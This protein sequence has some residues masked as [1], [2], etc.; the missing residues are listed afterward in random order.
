MT[1]TDFLKSTTV[2]DIKSSVHSNPSIRSIFVNAGVRDSPY[3][4][5]KFNEYCSENNI[6]LEEI[7]KRA[8][9]IS[10][11]RIPLELYL[12]EDANHKVDKNRLI[13]E[14]LLEDKCYTENCEIT[15]LWLGKKIT[16]ELD[17]ID[18][19]HRNNLIENL[20]LLC[21][22][23]HSQQPTSNR[24]KTFVTVEKEVFKCISC[25]TKILKGSKMCDTC[26]R[27]SR[28]RAEERSD[29]PSVK[30][31]VILVRESSFVAVGKTLGVSDNGL[32]KY[33]R[34]FGVD[35]KTI[36]NK[37]HAVVYPRATDA[38]KG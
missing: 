28:K 8:Q 31:L 12:V 25:G 17:H 6:S 2:D 29:W 24:R 19:N 36:K 27:S 23:C 22:N 16:L 15:S 37:Q 20:R 33:L 32:R 34:N 13:K 4:Y 1:I 10:A 11:N 5:R 9:Y 26:S 38:L 18:G 21:P 7:K 35:P 14:G 3:A 30:E